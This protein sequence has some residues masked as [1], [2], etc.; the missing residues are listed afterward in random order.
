MAVQVLNTNHFL[1]KF[2]FLKI[3]KCNSFFQNSNLLSPYFAKSTSIKLLKYQAGFWLGDTPSKHG[4]N[5]QIAVIFIAFGC[6]VH[7]TVNKSCNFP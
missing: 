7:F 5:F 6:E 1:P 3:L 2:H 4:P